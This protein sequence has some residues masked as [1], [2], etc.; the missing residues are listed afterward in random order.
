VRSWHR[1]IAERLVSGYSAG[2][3]SIAAELARHFDMGESVEQAIHFY[4]LAG[5]RAE[6]RSGGAEACVT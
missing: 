1:R 2:T 4:D 6:R 3:E 5:S